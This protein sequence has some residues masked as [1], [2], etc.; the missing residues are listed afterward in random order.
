MPGKWDQLWS[1]V[2][3]VYPSVLKCDGEKDCDSGEDE[4]NCG[5]GW[6]GGCI[7]LFEIDLSEKELAGQYTWEDK[8]LINISLNLFVL[9]PS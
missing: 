3:P 8:F 1:S 7:T 9:Q 6:N 2:N 4:E 5:K